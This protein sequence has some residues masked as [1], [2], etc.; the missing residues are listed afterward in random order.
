MHAAQR[1]FV[2]ATRDIDERKIDELRTELGLQ[3]LTVVR[4][5]RVPLI[6]QFF[7]E[8]LLKRPDLVAQRWAL[9]APVIRPFADALRQD[10]H[11]PTERILIT[12]ELHD[13]VSQTFVDAGLQPPLTWALPTDEDEEE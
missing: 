8:T 13:A 3:D 12:K 2:H 6:E 5:D 11:S 4:K 9:V 1:Q 10:A 7:R